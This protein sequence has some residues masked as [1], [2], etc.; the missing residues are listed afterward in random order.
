MSREE[1]ARRAVQILR[2][3]DYTPQESNELIGNATDDRRFQAACAAMQG[4]LARDTFEGEPVHYAKAA[5]A[6]ADAL[7]AA[8]SAGE[9]EK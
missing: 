9:G 5:V 4:L 8:L 7:L 3:F 6:A 2:T 1:R